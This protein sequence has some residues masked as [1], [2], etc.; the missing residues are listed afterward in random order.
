MV[1][2]VN[3]ASTSSVPWRLQAPSYVKMSMTSPP[4][5]LRDVHL[6]RQ[7]VLVGVLP[8]VVYKL[9]ATTSSAPGAPELL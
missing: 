4:G 6:D 5:Q 3:P 9:C 8:H 2:S 1:F 7:P